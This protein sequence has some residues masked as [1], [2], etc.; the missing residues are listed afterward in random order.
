MLHSVPLLCCVFVP[1]TLPEEAGAGGFFFLK[2]KV[3]VL[4]IG[5]SSPRVGGASTCWPDREREREEY[6]LI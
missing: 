4:G 3:L 1:P 5:S 2:L 6:S